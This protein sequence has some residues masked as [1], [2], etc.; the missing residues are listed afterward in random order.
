[1]SIRWAGYKRR[2]A[3]PE[4]KDEPEGGIGVG[5][6]GEHRRTPRTLADSAHSAGAY[7]RDQR[8]DLAGPIRTTLY[9]GKRFPRQTIELV[10]RMAE[11]I[12]IP[13]H[14]R[15]EQG[16]IRELLESLGRSRRGGGEGRPLVVAMPE[17][18]GRGR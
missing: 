4:L 13:S 18:G 2:H 6:Q 7:V 17:A 14:C 15:G 11:V 9:V 16:L 12:Q 8:G 3:T 5:R 1:M 10:N